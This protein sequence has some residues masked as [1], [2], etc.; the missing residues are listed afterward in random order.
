MRCD[1][2]SEDF[3][4]Y[5]RNDI[6]DDIYITERKIFMDKKELLKN[7]AADS[8]T[9]NLL[10]SELQSQLNEELK[11]PFKKQDF[12]KIEQLTS[13]IRALAGNEDAIKLRNEC[14]KRYLLERAAQKKRRSVG[15]IP[16][17]I[18]AAALCCL[19]VVLGLNAYSFSTWGVNIFS[20]VVKYTQ[21]GV[22]LDFSTPDS[23]FSDAESSEADSYGI[24][25]KCAKYGVECEAPEYMPDGF[26][27]S[28]FLCE[29]LSDSTNCYFYYI[30]GDS[31]LN[32]T[33]EKYNDSELIPPV[34]IPNEEHDVE[35]KFISGK[36]VYIMNNENAYTAVYSSGNIVYLIYTEGL[37]YEK[38]EKIIDSME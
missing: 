14:G 4:F 29:E 6:P 30:N 22:S 21:S 28:D 13:S 16:V 38:L 9:E 15:K 23:G 24:K 2:V 12:D 7:I 10:L 3:Y 31:R 33:I 5:G 26:E 11:K 1:K 34:L 20:A 8:E 17:T 25:E 19:T 35:Q 37:G 18:L 27:L 32:L 36:L